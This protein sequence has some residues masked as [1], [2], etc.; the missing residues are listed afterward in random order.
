[1]FP[2]FSTLIAHLASGTF[3]VWLGNAVVGGGLLGAAVVGTAIRTFVHGRRSEQVSTE[4]PNK[5]PT[6][7]EA[8]A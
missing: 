2:G 5:K 4:L 8:R 7:K 6:K 1:M 3:I